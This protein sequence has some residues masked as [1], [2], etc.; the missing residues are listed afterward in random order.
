MTKFSKG[1]NIELDL[2]R[3]AANGLLSRRHLL[4]AALGG[5]GLAMARPVIGQEPGI[6]LEIPAWSKTPGRKMLVGQ[7]FGEVYALSQFKLNFGLMDNTDC[8]IGFC[9]KES[10]EKSLGVFVGCIL[11][12]FTVF[13]LNS[14][15]L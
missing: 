11:D 10:L 2:D 14:G 9:G 13:F 5:A 4:S 12:S 15:I 7:I 1:Q 8:M 6:N 3:V